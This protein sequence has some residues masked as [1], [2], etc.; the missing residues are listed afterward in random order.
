MAFALQSIQ[1]RLPKILGPVI[2]GYVLDWAARSW[3]TP[4]AGRVAGMR[5][6]VLAALGLGLISLVVQWTY[7]PRRKP[8]PAGD[9]ALA[10]LRAFPHRLRALLLAEVFTRWCDWMVR[11]FVVLYLMQV[12][13]LPARQV[14]W[15]FAVQHTTALITYLPVGRMTRSTGL[16]P[17]V[18]LT[19]VFF[20]LFP[21][22]LVLVPG[23][24][25]WLVVAF[26]VYGLREIGE[27]ARKAMITNMVPEEVRAR[28]VGL[29][30]GVRSVTICPAAL[31][32]AAVWIALGPQAS[33]LSAFACGCAGAAVFYALV[34][35]S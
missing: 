6:L 24:F 9:G 32:G 16:Q 18:G 4:E 21:L 5:L 15:L 35:S 33:F 17:F 23:S 13:G 26:V 2:A 29:Y 1:K 28:G 11:S 7:M 22:T 30:W 34:R 25:W 12:R 8:P 14:G 31:A 10:V 19:F 20:A 3:E 27:P